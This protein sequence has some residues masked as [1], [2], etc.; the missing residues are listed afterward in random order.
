MSGSEILDIESANEA[1]EYFKRKLAGTLKN[2]ITFR[3]RFHKKPLL[4]KSD[5]RAGNIR[6]LSQYEYVGQ[7]KTGKA[8][9]DYAVPIEYGRTEYTVMRVHAFGRQ[10]SPHEVTMAAQKPNPFMRKAL[11]VNADSAVRIFMYELS[12]QVTDLAKQQA[13]KSRRRAKSNLRA[14]IR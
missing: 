8:S 2:D 10:V 1:E 13:S 7:V 11:D 3:G 4:Y 6:N 12:R 9:Q 5:R 14:N